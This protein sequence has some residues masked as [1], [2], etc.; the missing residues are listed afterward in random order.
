[1]GVIKPSCLKLILGV[2]KSQIAIAAGTFAGLR[3]A[4][5]FDL[6][7]AASSARF[8]CHQSYSGVPGRGGTSFGIP[9][10]H[11]GTWSATTPPGLE[12]LAD[13]IM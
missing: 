2:T 9:P 3:D 13:S 8:L 10:S 4:F 5:Y 6:T 1:M 11:I 7:A 12:A